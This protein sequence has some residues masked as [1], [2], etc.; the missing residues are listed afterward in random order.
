MVMYNECF[1]VK[2][3]FNGNKKTPKDKLLT[4]YILLM[5]VIEYYFYV[6]WNILIEVWN[7]N[8]SLQC[9][10]WWYT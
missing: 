7:I 5:H 4:L 2:F 9:T 3:V 10:K 6:N 8:F 1:F